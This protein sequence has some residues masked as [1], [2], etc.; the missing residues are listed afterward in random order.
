M[1]FYRQE[2]EFSPRGLRILLAKVEISG[3][4]TKFRPQAGDWTP[5]ELWD[6]VPK[7]KNSLKK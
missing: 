1:S 2:G 6:S 3:G 5:I 4:E 7:G